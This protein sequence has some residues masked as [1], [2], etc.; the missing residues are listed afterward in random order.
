MG[1][2]ERRKKELCG[3]RTRNLRLNATTPN[4]YTTEADYLTSGKVFDLVPFEW[5]FRRKMITLH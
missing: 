1:K 5:T 3:I 2:K 4:H